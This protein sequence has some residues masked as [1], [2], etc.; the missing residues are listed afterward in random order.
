M[1]SF[2][3]E[4]KQRCHYRQKGG[5]S[6]QPVS[7][8]EDA[9]SSSLGVKCSAAPLHL[10]SENDV[11]GG[12]MVVGDVS[13]LKRWDL[14]YDRLFALGGP[15]ERLFTSTMRQPSFKNA[16]LG[17]TKLSSYVYRRASVVL[18]T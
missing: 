10:S 8:H 16:M 4:K 14:V 3:L 7:P 6:T 9:A 13:C 15:S 1:D 18:R 17:S 5:G 2:C 11:D 12:A